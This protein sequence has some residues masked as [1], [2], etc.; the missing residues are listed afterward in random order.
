MN[1][2]FQLNFDQ[3]SK[4]FAGRMI[5]NN[6]E[7]NLTGGTCVQLSGANGSGKST[8]LRIMAG[9]EKPE[10]GRISLDHS[11]LAWR[12]AR[13]YLQSSIMYLHQQPYMFDGSVAYNLGYSL[14]KLSSLERQNR[15]Q[16]ALAWAGL[17]HLAEADACS[18]SGGEKQ[19]V[20]L[21]RAMLHQPRAMLLDEPTAN[22]DAA[23]RSKT[24]MLLQK[25]KEEGIALVITCHDPSHFHNLFDLTYEL[26]DGSLQQVVRYP[27]DLNVSG[28]ITPFAKVSA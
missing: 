13:N 21:A 9:L 18:L 17:E 12:S 10:H 23:S 8:L 3:L 26:S 1:S 4:H 19:R 5:L 7:I 6:V 15:I 16:Q 11:S 14:K 24:F 2:L 27:N 28:N 25:L 22:L 20:A